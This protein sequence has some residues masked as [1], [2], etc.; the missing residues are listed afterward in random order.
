MK[1]IRILHIVQKS[2]ITKGY[3]VQVE[4]YTKYISLEKLNEL[5]DRG[6]KVVNAIR[7][8]GYFRAIEGRLP[9]IEIKEVVKEIEERVNSNSNNY[10]AKRGTQKKYSVV[11]NLSG[12]ENC[13]ISIGTNERTN[14]KDKITVY[15]GT[16]CKNLVPKYGKGYIYCDYGQGFYTTENLELAREW[17]TISA[18][19]K[20]A[21]CCGFSFDNRSG[22]FNIL[23]IEKDYSLLDWFSVLFYY[24]KD[25]TYERVNK[26][27]YDSVCKLVNSRPIIKVLEKGNVDVV[28]GW[29]ADSLYR[30][31]FEN[32]L[33]CSFNISELESVLKLGNYGRQV[34]FKS[35]RAIESL[36]KITEE[37]VN[38]EFYNRKYTER[39]TRAMYEMYQ[40]VKSKG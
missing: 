11:E 32:V 19:D 22:N 9:V 29:R 12:L 14:F 39:D 23:D 4:K 28:V 20:K 6:V 3:E 21:Y 31:I 1:S 35:K 27:D 37:N 34:F 30:H 33:K 16:A 26:N 15:H 24:R 40:I 2:G 8:N 13:K 38:F 17:A 25:I 5:C 18:S 36:V 7:V 10:S